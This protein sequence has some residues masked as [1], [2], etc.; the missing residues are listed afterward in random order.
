PS[1]VLLRRLLEVA[2]N[3]PAAQAI[4]IMNQFETYRSRVPEWEKQG[5][6]IVLMVLGDHY[7]DA[8]D[9]D[10]A[11]S[12]FL[13]AIK[14]ASTELNAYYNAANIYQTRK[15]DANWRTVMLDAL[16]LD[17]TDFER[18]ETHFRMADH[19][20]AAKQWTEALPHAETAA[21]TNAAFGL[22]SAS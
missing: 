14:R 12:Y 8:K 5:H 15:D 17:G 11:L 3:A 4:A 9:D 20:M 1:V 21:R 13:D 22:L 19:Y 7:A 16:K 10:R 6:P 2:P 18:A